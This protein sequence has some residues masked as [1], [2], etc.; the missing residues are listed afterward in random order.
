MQPDIENVTG[1]S[2]L[3]LVAGFIGS[4]LQLSYAKDLTR[5]QAV[6]ALALGTAVAIYGAPLLLLALPDSWHAAALERGIAFF[7][8]LFAM[9]L[10]PVL[11]DMIS[12]NLRKF[13]FPGTED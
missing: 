1:V 11:Q 13:K 7:L 3:T 5:A 9:P 6:T 8:G 4:A 10:V 2:L 12:T